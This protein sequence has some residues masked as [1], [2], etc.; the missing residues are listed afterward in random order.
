MIFDTDL[1]HIIFDIQAI[2]VIFFFR[3]KKRLANKK[4]SIFDSMLFFFYSYRTNQSGFVN[5]QIFFKY[6]K[7]ISNAR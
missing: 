6:F 4:I 5:I 7:Y 3:N 1:P 2:F